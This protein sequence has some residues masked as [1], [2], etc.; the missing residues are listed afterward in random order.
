[1]NALSTKIL[2]GLIA[3]GLWANAIGSYVRPA[4]AQVDETLV[5]QI[6][7]DVSQIAAAVRALVRGGAGCRNMKICD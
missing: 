2:L 3:A 1:M 7:T 6:Q 5:M 4:H